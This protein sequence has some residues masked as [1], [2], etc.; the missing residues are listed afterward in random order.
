MYIHNAYA[1]AL[2]HFK[3][4]TILKFCINLGFRKPPLSKIQNKASN[5][6]GSNICLTNPLAFKYCPADRTVHVHVNKLHRGSTAQ[7]HKQKLGKS[8]SFLLE[9]RPA[10]KEYNRR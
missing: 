3:F 4:I 7:T 1:F 6:D 2:C 8:D 9:I 5:S 10:F